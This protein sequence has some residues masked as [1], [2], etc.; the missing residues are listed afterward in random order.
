MSY[1]SPDEQ[2]RYGLFRFR[3]SPYLSGENGRPVF[4]VSAGCQSVGRVEQRERAYTRCRGNCVRWIATA[5]DGSEYGPYTSRAE[6]A[7][8][9]RWHEV[10]V[11]GLNV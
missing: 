2:L 7:K 4:E 9:L 3:R 8:A 10:Q 11:R 6:A 1:E 5:G